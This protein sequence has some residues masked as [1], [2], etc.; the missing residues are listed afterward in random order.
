VVFDGNRWRVLS[1]LWEPNT[2]AGPV[3]EKYLP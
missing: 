1:V 2:T 3:P